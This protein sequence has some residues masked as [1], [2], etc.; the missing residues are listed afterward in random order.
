MGSAETIRV[1]VRVICA[2]N[3]DIPQ[4]IEEGKFRED[5]YYR[6][7]QFPVQLPPLRERDQD[8]MLL[9]NFFREDFLKRHKDVKPRTFSTATKQ[10]IL[11]YNWPG[12]VRQLKNAVERGITC[13]RQRRN[14][15]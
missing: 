4:L 9:A 1:D 12:N 2:T 5:L 14:H 13:F 6:L 3:R 8:A 10:L 7:F 11:E 15:S